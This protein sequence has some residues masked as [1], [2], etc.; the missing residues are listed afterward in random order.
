[1][2]A[3]HVVLTPL[4]LL[5]VITYMDRVSIAYAGPQRQRDSQKRCHQPQ[6]PHSPVGS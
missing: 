1:M 5:S 6:N 4:V 3:R 2:K